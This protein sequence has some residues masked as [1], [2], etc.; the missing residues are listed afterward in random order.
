MGISIVGGMRGQN[1]IL[2][3]LTVRKKHTIVVLVHY[4][5]TRLPF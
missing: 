4:I 5:S 3:E 1:L 2:L